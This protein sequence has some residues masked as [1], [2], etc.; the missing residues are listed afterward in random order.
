MVDDQGRVAD[1]WNRTLLDWLLFVCV[2]VAIPAT[3]MW[4]LR[5]SDK[6]KMVVLSSGLFCL[7]AINAYFAIQLRQ[8]KKRAGESV[9]KGFWYGLFVLTMTS[10]GIT[11][12]GGCYIAARNSYL[13]L[14]LSSTPLS[15][16]HPER[17][18]LVVELMRNRLSNSR[19]NDKAIAEA[20]R[21]PITPPL[22]S[23]R[24]FA[25]KATID[26]VQSQLRKAAETDHNYFLKQRQAMTE[27]ED[28]MAT[29]DPA[30][31]RSWEIDRE[32]EDEAESATDQL[33]VVWFNATNSLYDYAAVH[34]NQISVKNGSLEFANEGIREAFV[35]QEDHCKA[36]FE[37]LQERV[38]EQAMTHRKPMS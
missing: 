3:V 35:T 6:N 7:V 19:E 8:R 17:K 24:S 26:S 34:S 36:I 2:A 16:I 5:S 20:R 1:Q 37:K 28:K 25:D 27:F 13:A 23:P 22:Y 18:R 11:I 4:E 33:Q 29:V 10:A 15:E 14:T 30:Y 31:L 32:P 21:H 12:W 38:Q 9:G